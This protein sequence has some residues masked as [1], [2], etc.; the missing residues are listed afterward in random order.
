MLLEKKHC[1]KSH[2]HILPRDKKKFSFFAGVLLAL[3]PKCPLCFMAFSSTFI[4]CD[5]AGTFTDTHIH[6]S[7]TTLILSALFCGITLISIL[8]NYSGSRTKYAL[9][10]ALAG[11]ASI[12]YSVA[13]GGGLILYYCGVIL[14]FC[15]IWMNGG[16]LSFMKKTRA[17]L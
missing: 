5:E 7:L 15:S 9:L 2:R 12:L 3:L 17:S 6:S 1:V 13:A 14:I 10:L 16:L 8:F 4:L 11:S